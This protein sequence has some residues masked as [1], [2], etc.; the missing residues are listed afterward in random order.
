MEKNCSLLFSE[1]EAFG[2]AHCRAIP[3]SGAAASP[4]HEY[5]EVPH[6]FDNLDDETTDNVNSEN[7]T[8]GQLTQDIED[9][10]VSPEYWPILMPSSFWPKDHPH[11]RIELCLH[12]EQAYCYVM[13]LHEVISKKSFQYTHV[14]RAAPQKA[15]CP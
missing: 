10:N 11:S 5:E 4:T 15:V 12:K 8:S 6:D 1:F 13:V 14:I 9:T 7:I 2:W 3:A